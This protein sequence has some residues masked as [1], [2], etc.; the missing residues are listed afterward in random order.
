MKLIRTGCIFQPTIISLQAHSP[1][2]QRAIVISIRNFL[3]CL[4]GAIGLAVEAAILQNTLRKSLPVKFSYLAESTYSHPNFDQFSPED[5]SDIIDAYAKAS[6]TVF[7][8]LAPLAGVCLLT[9]IFVKDR[10]L[11]RKEDEDDSIHS[12]SDEEKQD[13]DLEH[14]QRRNSSNA[15][16]CGSGKEKDEE[17]DAR[18][19]KPS[20]PEVVSKS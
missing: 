9:C 17:R 19:A 10:G 5:A 20:F 13:S 7:V 1:K 11:T 15:S 2:A 4:G 6:R 8:F 14:E 18:F 12:S 16:L 3:R